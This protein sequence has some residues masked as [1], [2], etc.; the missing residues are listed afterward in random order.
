MSIFCKFIKRITFVL[1]KFTWFAAQWEKALL[2]RLDIANWKLLKTIISDRDRKFLSEMWTIIFKKLKIKLLYFTV[3]H[4]Q[5]NDQFERTNQTIEI[6]LRFHLTIMKNSRKWLVVLSKIQRHLNN[7]VSTTIDK[8]SNEIVYEFISFQVDDF[9][10]VFEI[11][12]IVDVDNQM[13]IDAFVDINFNF[14]IRV[15]VK[16]VDSIIFAQMKIKRNYDN[17]HKSIYMREKDYILIKLH[18]DYDIF[19]IV[20]LEFK[21]SQQFVEFFRVLKRVERLVYRLNFSTH[22]HIHSILFIIQLEL[23]SALSDDSFNR[24]RSNHSNFVFVE[25]DI[26]RVKFYEIDKLIDKRQIKRRDSEYLVRWKEY[27]VQFDE[28]RNLFEFDDVMKLIRNYE[29]IQNFIA[30]LFDR[31]QLFNSSSIVVRFLTIKVKVKR[32]RFAKLITKFS[33]IE[34][35]NTKLITKSSTIESAIIKS[36]TK[37]STIDSA[38][39]S[40]SIFTVSRSIIKSKSFVLSTLSV[41]VLIRKSS[42]LLMNQWSWIWMND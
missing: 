34:S 14:A 35:A 23:I 24:S 40:T 8:N 32:D 5:T 13:F 15:R 37:L 12:I 1:N 6:T 41:D 25:D 28:W 21:F 20:V 26:E 19:F 16:I 36:I 3:Y 11:V 27:D 30:H 31:V 39:T 7:V 33:T 2:N 18:H 10:K 4:S 29:N 22:W 42:R 9:W 38:N 17:K